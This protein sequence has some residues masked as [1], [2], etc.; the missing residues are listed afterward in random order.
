MIETGFDTQNVKNK[1]F[2]DTTFR[3]FPL[4]TGAG[5]IS[6]ESLFFLSCLLTADSFIHFW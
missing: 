6:D 3:S 5:G 4:A 2:P 1:I